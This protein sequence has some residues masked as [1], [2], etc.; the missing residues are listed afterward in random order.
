MRIAKPENL[1]NLDKNCLNSGAP[2]IGYVLSE[3]E[4]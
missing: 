4:L 1:D 3:L 2:E